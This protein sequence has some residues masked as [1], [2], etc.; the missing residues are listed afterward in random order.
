MQGDILA[1]LP[2][3]VNLTDFS[4]ESDSGWLHWV[5]FPDPFKQ[6]LYAI[7]SL[8]GLTSLRLHN[9]RF[10][11][12]TELV[13]LLQCSKKLEFLVLPDVPVDIT[14]KSRLSSLELGRFHFPLLHC[15][16][17]TFDLQNLQHLQTTIVSSGMEMEIQQIL[18]TTKT[19]RYYHAQLAHES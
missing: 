7:V 16:K 13:S 11:R 12:S 8:P 5:Y 19:L 15:V 4:M 2:M 6:A 9:V 14:D 18:Q 10:E 1:I 3:L 17:S